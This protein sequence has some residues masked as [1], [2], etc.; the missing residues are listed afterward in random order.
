MLNLRDDHHIHKIN[1]LKI[2]IMLKIPAS[3]ELK[4]YTNWQFNRANVDNLIMAEII[5]LKNREL[6]ILNQTNSYK[7][8]SD[9]TFSMLLSRSVSSLTAK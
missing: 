4:I 6:Y 1:N 8:S 2:E 3:N 9:F 7:L 5:V